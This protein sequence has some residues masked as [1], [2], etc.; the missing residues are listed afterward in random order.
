MVEI[1]GERTLQFAQGELERTL[2]Q[3]IHREALDSDAATSRGRGGAEHAAAAAGARAENLAVTQVD[4]RAACQGG[5]HAA[6]AAGA[7]AENLAVT[8]VDAR[9]AYGGNELAAVAEASRVESLAMTLM[10]VRRRLSGGN[11]ERS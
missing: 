9:A 1:D 10:G 5:E 3:R 2:Q 6:A 4:A 8:Q 11:A 7:H